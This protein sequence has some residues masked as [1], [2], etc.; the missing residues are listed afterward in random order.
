[1]K[2]QMNRLNIFSKAFLGY[3]REDETH[4]QKVWRANELV[5]LIKKANLKLTGIYDSTQLRNLIKDNINL[6]DNNSP[7][8]FFIIKNEE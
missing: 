6:I 2:K 8:L 1:K 5:E 7:R 4:Q 3:R